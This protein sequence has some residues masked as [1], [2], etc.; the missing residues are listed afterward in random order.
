MFFYKCDVSDNARVEE[1]WSQ[2]L[3]QHGPVHI[4]INNAAI[5]MGLRVDELSMNNVKQMMD[6]NFNA[7][8]HFIILFLK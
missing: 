8:V 5:A 3:A 6:T 4:L 2:I 7:Y 1:V